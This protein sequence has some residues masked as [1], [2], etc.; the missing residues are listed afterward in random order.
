MIIKAY[1]VPH[2][3]I[4]LPE[5]GRGEERRIENTT[6]SFQRMAHEIELL[7]PDTIVLS[8]PHAPAYADGFYIAGGDGGYGDLRSFGIPHVREEVSLD[9]TFSERLQ[10]HWPIGESTR[11]ERRKDAAVLTMGR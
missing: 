6:L 8:S 9:R 7:A 2:P 10:S 1:A 4:I 11:R 5:V 3:P